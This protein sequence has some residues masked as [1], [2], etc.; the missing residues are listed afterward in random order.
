MYL[1]IA[2]FSLSKN[3]VSLHGIFVSDGVSNMS[4]KATEQAVS[5]ENALY[6]QAAQELYSTWV[7]PGLYSP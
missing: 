5:R 6:R 2:R 1:L 4:G 3:R 7:W